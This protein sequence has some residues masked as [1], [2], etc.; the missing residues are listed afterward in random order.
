MAD[1]ELI[2]AH[3]A[4]LARRL[5]ADAVDELADGLAETYRHHLATGADPHSA[6]RRALTEFGTP[7]QITAA[8]TALSPGRGAA[9]TLLMT[10]PPVGAVWAIALVT[11]HAWQWPIPTPARLA[12][13]LLMLSATCALIIG[14]TGRARYAHTRTAVLAGGIGLIALDAAALT[15]LALAAPTMAWPLALAASASLTR[16]AMTARTLPPVLST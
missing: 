15:G 16:I 7:D 12:I 6:A 13:G 14:A 3:L 2:Q 8:F 10:G 9:R 4:E 5:P 1:H 11:G